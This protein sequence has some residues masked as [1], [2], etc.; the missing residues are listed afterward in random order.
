MPSQRLCSSAEA[1]AYLGV[2]EEALRHMVRRGQ[3]GNAV[4]RLTDR[5]LSFDLRALDRLID[6]RRDQKAS[7]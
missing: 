3:L 4:V 6:A 7:A 5:R 2:S 1:A